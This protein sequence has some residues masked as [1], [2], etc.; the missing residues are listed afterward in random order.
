LEFF[1]ISN[2]LKGGLDNK[3]FLE[4]ENINKNPNN[5]LIF[6]ITSE[7]LEMESNN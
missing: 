1:L 3:Y 6:P 5:L 7:F 4:I 2:D